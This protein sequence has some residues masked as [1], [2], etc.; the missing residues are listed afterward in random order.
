LKNHE[1]PKIIIYKS[2]R[3]DGYYFV[4]FGE[5]PPETI[6]C[7]CVGF[8]YRKKCKHVVDAV[9]RYVRTQTDI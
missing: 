9:R 7:T 4:V 5:K 6:S 1:F 2:E 3:G 8:S